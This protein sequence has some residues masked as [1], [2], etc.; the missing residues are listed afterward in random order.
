MFKPSKPRHMNLPPEGQL[1]KRSAIKDAF[2]NLQLLRKS[3]R[4]H[5]E[6]SSYQ[7]AVIKQAR[8]E[9]F[10]PKE[11]EELTGLS[12]YRVQQV[13]NSATRTPSPEPSLEHLPPGGMPIMS[14]PSNDD[15]NNAIA[16]D[17]GIDP[18]ELR[19]AL[20]SPTVRAERIDWAALEVC[21]HGYT[22]AD[23]VPC[24]VITNHGIS[25][26]A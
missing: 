9:R 7:I 3:D 12:V 26:H 4:N 17:L 10:T 5:S 1:L 22:L 16:N 11:L 23:G 20:I 13:V 24:W 25:H 8:R 18:S 19:A 15:T 21:E 14:V 2:A 6:L